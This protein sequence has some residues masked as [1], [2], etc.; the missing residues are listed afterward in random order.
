LRSDSVAGGWLSLR[1]DYV[2]PSQELESGVSAAPD[3]IGSAPEPSRFPSKEE[4]R[5]RWQAAGVYGTGFVPPPE[6]PA[7]PH[8]ALRA[9]D[10]GRHR[11][12]MSGVLE[13]ASVDGDNATSPA[14]PGLLITGYIVFVAVACIVMWILVRS[15]IVGRP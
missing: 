1:S 14:S 2:R 4:Q 13:P 12:E 9:I 3:R 8:D 10:G 6:L 11:D 5:Q 15:L 7:Q